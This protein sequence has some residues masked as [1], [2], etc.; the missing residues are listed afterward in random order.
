M[1]DF[2]RFLEDAISIAKAAGDVQLE[3]F[4]SKRLDIH[5]KLND[6]DVVTAADKASEELVKSIIRSK[7]PEHGIIAEESGCENEDKK[8]RWVIDP[9]DGTTNFSQGLPVFC[10]S[11]ALEHCGSPVVGVVFAPYLGE[12]F[13]AV[14]GEGAFLNGKRIYCS[15]KNV[16]SESVLATGMPYDKLVNPDNNLNEISQLAPKVRGI[17]R[18]GSAAIDL[19]YVA[20]GFYDAYWELNLK[21]WDVAAGVL[22]AKEAGAK[23]YSI[24]TNR[25]YSLMATCPGIA[26][27]MVGALSSVS[28]FVPKEW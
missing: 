19:S 18:M 6:S 15:E 14:K 12:L 28:G 11:I 5:T 25:N 26:G 1:N 21:R 20:A 8:W 24:R 9:L 2:S 17:R 27:D 10:V 16:F 22:I 4:R 23:V 3:F 7:Y 13:H